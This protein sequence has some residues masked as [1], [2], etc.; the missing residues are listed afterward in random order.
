[1]YDT[2]AVCL[3]TDD[4]GMICRA[5]HADGGDTAAVRLTLEMV[6]AEFAAI[7]ENAFVVEASKESVG[8]FN[9]RVY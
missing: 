2:D 4:D 3:Q 5:D 8:F 9:S 6:R 7:E 1:M